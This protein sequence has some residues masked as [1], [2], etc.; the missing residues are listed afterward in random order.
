MDLSLILQVKEKL[1]KFVKPKLIEVGNSFYPQHD[2]VW[3][4]L[5]N[6]WLRR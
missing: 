5:R 6:V 1:E 4:Y 3:E 2:R